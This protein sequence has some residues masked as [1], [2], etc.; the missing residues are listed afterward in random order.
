MKLTTLHTISESTCEAE[1]V[2]EERERNIVS[3]GGPQC[4]KH[5]GR[6][7]EL[8][9]GKEIASEAMGISGHVK[10][11]CWQRDPELQVDMPK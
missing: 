7:R 10:D 8:K 6:S 2:T 1:R 9:T 5:P 3:R 4:K 11:S